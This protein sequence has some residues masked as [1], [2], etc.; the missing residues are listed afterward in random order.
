ML[1]ESSQAG[2]LQSSYLLWE[3]N[4][5]AA[6]S[7]NFSFTFLI[8]YSW[9]HW[10]YWLLYSFSMS[11][12]GTF[13]HSIYMHSNGLSKLNKMFIFYFVCVE[14]YFASILI[15]TLGQTEDDFC[16]PYLNFRW[17]IQAGTSNVSEPSGTMLAKDAGRHR[18]VIEDRKLPLYWWS[19]WFNVFFCIFSLV[20]AFILPRSFTVIIQKKWRVC[21]LTAFHLS[22]FCFISR[23]HCP[24]LHLSTVGSSYWSTFRRCQEALTVNFFYSSPS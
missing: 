19:S 17:Q 12:T 7:L 16:F 23:F 18:W 2:C 1:E 20:M 6:V 21:L 15:A 24:L 22:W 3:Q 8:S 4:R 14:K 11:N 5:R 13:V 10:A 9:I